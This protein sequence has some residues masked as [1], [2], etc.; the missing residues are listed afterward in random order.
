MWKLETEAAGKRNA[1]SEADIDAALSAYSR[2]GGFVILSRAKEDYVQVGVGTLEYRRDGRHFQRDLAGISPAV[3]RDVF[4]SFFRDDGRWQTAVAW[5]DVSE[6]PL[7]APRRR[8]RGAGLLALAL[9]ALV[10]FA[11]WRLVVAR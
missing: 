2:D 11:F 8:S 3:V 4:V 6:A 10:G 5:R 1:P 9:I 7:S